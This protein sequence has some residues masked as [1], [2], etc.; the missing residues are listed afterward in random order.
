MGKVAA[1]LGDLVIITSDNPRNE[2]PHTIIKEIESG[3]KA[4]KFPFFEP[5]QLAVEG[6]GYT[7]EPDRKHAIEFALSLALPGDIVF[8]GGKGHETYQVIGSERFPFDDRLV[9]QEYL[10]RSLRAAGAQ[11]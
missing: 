9:A 6:R 11:R 10:Q 1:E 2:E 8:I 5:Q 4:L 7:I 3:V